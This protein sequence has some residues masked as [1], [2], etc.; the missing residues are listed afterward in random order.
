[1]PEWLRLRSI[2]VVSNDRQM[3]WRF[4]RDDQTIE[5]TL[6]ADRRTQY[7][8]VVR[9]PNGRQEAQRFESRRVAASPGQLATAV[10]HE[11][12]LV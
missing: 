5:L 4:T 8:T 6:S 9:W 2:K 10:A 3:R 7:E 12:F 1:M 11:Q